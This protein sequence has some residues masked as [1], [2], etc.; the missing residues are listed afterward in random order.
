M[1]ALRARKRAHGAD[2]FEL[3]TELAS[4]PRRAPLLAA[5]AAAPPDNGG[6]A[7]S[8][9][10]RRILEH[11]PGLP[12]PAGGH[13]GALAARFLPPS[14]PHPRLPPRPTGPPPRPER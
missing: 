2:F 11:H 6:A 9:Q 4:R 7:P 10:R 1:A 13:D 12:P 3:E 14:R 5:V 8:Q